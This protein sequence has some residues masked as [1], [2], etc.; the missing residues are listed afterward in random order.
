MGSDWNLFWLLKLLNIRRD[1]YLYQ[2]IHCKH[3]L[4]CILD[5][6]EYM[7]ALNHHNTFNKE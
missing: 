4:I 3:W 6:H 5:Y 1:E 2:S 7:F